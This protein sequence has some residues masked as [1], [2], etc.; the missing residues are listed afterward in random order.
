MSFTKALLDGYTDFLFAQLHSNVLT[1]DS[2]FPAEVFY[3]HLNIL[4]SLCPFMR[5]YESKLEF[6][7]IGIQGNADGLLVI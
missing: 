5:K 7:Y 3:D 4:L 6:R 1:L 2:S